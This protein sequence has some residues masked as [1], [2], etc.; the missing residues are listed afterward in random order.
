MQ[1]RPV[2]DTEWLEEQRAKG[3]SGLAE[4]GLTGYMEA[5]AS[6]LPK[7]TWPQATLLS[8]IEESQVKTFGWPIGI[9]LNRDNLRPH[10]T[11]EGV[12]A[13]VAFPAR[14]TFRE[15]GS[16][17]YWYMRRTGD[18][19]MLQSLFEDERQPGSIF[20]DTRIIRATELLLFLARCYARLEAV[21]STQLH[22]QVT[23]GGLAG[24]ELRAAA[25]NRMVVPGRTT[26]EELVTSTI[27]CTLGELESELVELVADVVRPLFVMFDFFEVS[28]VVLAGIVNAY[29]NGQVT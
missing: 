9:V 26:Q 14:E 27:D 4:I 22:I 3:L 21:D 15:H 7:G 11:A 5:S 10:P 16:Y 20:L 28:N 17:D 1:S 25:P 23:H 8:A 6:L 19:Y 24:R 18:F 13:E 2:P 29:V 12:R